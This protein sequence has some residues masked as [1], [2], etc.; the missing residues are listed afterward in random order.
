MK[1]FINTDQFK[2][3]ALKTRED[4][5]RHVQKSNLEITQDIENADIIFSIG[6]D[7]TFL[8]S[9]RLSDEKPI[10]G[11]NTGTLGYLTEINPHD[12]K[13]ALN[14]IENGNYSIENRMMVE[15]EIIK[16]TGE[17]IKIPP[18]LNEIAISK[19][20]FGVVRFDYKPFIFICQRLNSIT[21]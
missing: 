2:D 7:G 3:I 18:A 11:I 17:I 15:G 1:I 13:R 5:I 4:L 19:N 8:K 12:I 20:T 14:D 9:A 16:T 21:L 10:I 6:G